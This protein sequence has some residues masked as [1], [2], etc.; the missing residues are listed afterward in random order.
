[1]KKEKPFK[2]KGKIFP[3]NLK[4]LKEEE[5][6]PNDNWLIKPVYYLELVHGLWGFFPAIITES[7]RIIITLD[8]DLLRRILEELPPRDSKINSVLFYVNKTEE[9]GYPADNYTKDEKASA[10]LL[11]TQKEFKLLIQKNRN[12]FKWTPGLINLV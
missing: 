3:L 9:V 12:P 7:E 6:I 1:M 2:F 10:F 4:I 5:E 8:E 11:I